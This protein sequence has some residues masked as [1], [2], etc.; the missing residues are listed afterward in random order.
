MHSNKTPKLIEHPLANISQ[1]DRKKVID[2][3]QKNAIE[4][5]DK[6]LKELQRL[7]KE[8]NPIVI[9]SQIANYA[10]LA[11]MGDK[12]IPTHNRSISQAHVEICQALIL[13]ISPNELN[14]K[15]PSPEIIQKII[16]LLEVLIDSNI[17]KN[18]DSKTLELSEKDI[19]IKFFRDYIISHTQ[20]VRNWGNFRQV[21]NISSELY[22]NFDEELLKVYGFSSS[23]IILFFNHLIK[24]IGKDSTDMLIEFRKVRQSSNITNMV[25]AYHKFIGTSEAESENLLKSFKKNN[26]TDKEYIFSNILY[27]YHTDQYLPK[28]FIFNYKD[29]AKELKLDVTIIESILNKFTL[30]VGDLSELKTEYLFLG[31]PIWTKPLIMISEEE[32]FCPLP[33]LFFSFIL[34]SFD[35]L[36]DNIKNNNLADIKAKYLEDKV[37]KIVHTR[38]LEA[39]I[40]KNFKWGTYENDLVIF[41]D[42]YII[43]IEAKSGKITDSALRGAPDRLKKKIDELLIAPNKQ[44]Q[45]LKEK[46]LYLI[47]NPQVEDEIRNKLPIPLTEDHK[48]LRV[49]V[50]LEYFASLQ[51]NISALKNTGWIPKDYTPCPSMNIAAFEMLFDIFEHPVQIINYLELREEIEGKIKYQGD[52]LD[53]IMTYIDNRFIFQNTDH[54]TIHMLTGMSKPIDDY[55]QLIDSGMK[56]DKIKIKMNNFFE[57]VLNQ[58]E[59]RK[60]HGWILMSSIIYRL[61]PDDQQMITDA[62]DKLKINVEKNW[63]IDGHDNML[64]YNPPISSQYAFSFILYNERNKEQRYD[65]F[66]DSCIMALEPE[67]VQYCLAIGINIDR[68]DIQYSMISVSNKDDIE[69]H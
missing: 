12:H 65:F 32:F 15:S 42:T 25:Y 3:I 4:N 69:Y 57:K 5:Y 9:L 23:D 27:A 36:I 44:S 41:I 17:W 31:N 55:Y 39:N 13:K 58:L 18:W 63:D 29:I 37:E 6:S 60:P 43:I 48:I 59:D 45:R 56:A 53:L 64:I 14:M 66:D 54:P 28:T 2:E 7:L 67:H 30:T 35:D 68:G 52:E 62:I 50:A 24:K 16:D 22:S 38:F 19:N 10:L 8:Y 51:S 20:V 47:D 26:I 40:I 21:N 46:L 34:K 61:F 33:Q 11:G 1:K 49:S